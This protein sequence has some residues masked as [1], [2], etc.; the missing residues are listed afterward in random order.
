M[1]AGVRAAPPA[2]LASAWRPSRPL[3]I[4]VPAPPGGITDIAA[5][6]LAA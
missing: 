6:I 2:A 4:I 5:R 1:L 3:R